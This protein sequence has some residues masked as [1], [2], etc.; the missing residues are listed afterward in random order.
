VLASATVTMPPTAVGHLWNRAMNTSQN[1]ST[2]CA[3][4]QAVLGDLD[5]LAASPL[6]SALQAVSTNALSIRLNVASSSSFPCL[7]NVCAR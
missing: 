6:L 5:A 3:G 7:R 4:Y 1:M 2:M